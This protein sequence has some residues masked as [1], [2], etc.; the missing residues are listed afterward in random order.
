MT[1]TSLAAAP[2]AAPVSVPVS[3]P[4]ALPALSAAD[5]DHL[6]P[7]ASGGRAEAIFRAAALILPLLE[8]GRPVD[9]AALGA[10]MA[11]AFG[12]TDS[13]GFWRWKNAYD[14]CEVAQALFIRKFGPAMRARAADPAT[15][16]A[17]LEKVAGLLPTH[18][19]RSAESQALQQLSTPIPLAFAAAQAAGLT[20]SDLVLE[21]SAGTGLLA[22]FAR[23][24]GAQLALNE[25]AETRA[26]LLGLAFPGVPVTRHDAAQIHDHL[27]PE[28]RPSAILMN[29]PFSAGAKVEGRVAGAALRHVSSALARLADGGRLVAITGANLTPENPSWRDAFMRLQE[30]SRVVFS[31]AIDGRVYARHGTS[32]EPRADAYGLR[33]AL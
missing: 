8:S 12:G 28:V 20:P 27:D 32:V 33:Y 29:P 6:R 19:K 9:T 24:F 26:A 16:L 3:Q 15:L 18:T 25:L 10:I 22:V 30:K 11:D 4:A 1:D 14:A 31:A 17:M 2:A 21:P 5:G 7:E 23:V 13:Q